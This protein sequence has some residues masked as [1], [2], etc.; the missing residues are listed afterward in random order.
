MITVLLLAL[1]LLVNLPHDS[2]DHLPDII[3][4]LR[5]GNEVVIRGWAIL[6]LESLEDKKEEIRTILTDCNIISL[7]VDANRSYSPSDT[8]A[9]IEIHLVR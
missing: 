3:P 1:L 8:Y 7:T 4:L 9:C 6:P 5:K 2:I